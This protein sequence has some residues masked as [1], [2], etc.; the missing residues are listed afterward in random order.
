MKN[1]ACLNFLEASSHHIRARLALALLVCLTQGCVSLEKIAINKMGDALAS[2]GTTFTSD[3]DPELVGAAM[4]FSLKLMETLLEQVPDH[5]GLLYATAS[6]FTQYGFAFVQEE[7]DRLEDTDLDAA[8]ALR[9]RAQKLY[10]RAR[11]YGLRGL[12]VSMPGF[13]AGMRE[14]PQKIVQK[15]A[16]EDVPLLYWTASA[17]ISAIAI[18]KEA[19]LIGDLPIVDALIDRALELDES[20]DYG[21]IH[22]F[23][24]TYEMNRGKDVELPE[25]RSRRHY[26]RAIELSGGLQAGPHLALA[27]AVSI[28]NQNRAEFRMLLYKALAIDTDIR[29]E[30]RLSNL[31]FQRRAQ[32]LLD[33]IERYFL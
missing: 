29:P 23:L 11:N 14:N 3:D 5:E 17:W 16:M 7:A 25:I 19:D 21:A 31:I 26:Q 27:E 24:I 2:G 18:S 9:N 20:Y 6:G 10:L 15:A 12:E 22:S 13:Q 33:R 30:W 32:W 28:P 8:F 1:I 4:P